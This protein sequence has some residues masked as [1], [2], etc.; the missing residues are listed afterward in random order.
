MET[1]DN[2]KYEELMKEEDP[3]DF[4][5]PYGKYRDMTIDDI[6]AK[7]PDYLEWIKDEWDDS[8][9]KTKVKKYLFKGEK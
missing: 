6:Y 4:Y 2:L 1:D 9:I 3:K 8:E 5:M 7:D